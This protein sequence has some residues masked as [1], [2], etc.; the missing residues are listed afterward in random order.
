MVFR[1]LMLVSALAM[2][3]AVLTASAQVVT[4]PRQWIVDL[5]ADQARDSNLRFQTPDDSADV[6]TH[7]TG[8]ITGALQGKRGRFALAVGGGATEFRQLKSF[9][10]FTYDIALD[11]KRALTP[12]WTAY[13][14]GDA[15]SILS[16]LAVPLS[17]SQPLLPLS[18]S[19]SQT[20]A[21]GTSYRFSTRTTGNLEG[22]YTRITFDA[23]LLIGGWT[24]GGQ[25]SLYH[26]YAPGQSIGTVYGFEENSTFGVRVDVQTLFAQWQPTLGFLGVRLLAGAMRIGALDGLAA[27]VKPAGSAALFTGLGGGIATVQYK[28]SAEQAFGLGRMLL[29]DHVGLVYDRAAFLGNTIHL[30]A[31]RSWSRNPSD[32]S[33]AFTNTSGSLEVRRTLMGGFFVAADVSLRRRDDNLI[34]RANALRMLIGFTRHGE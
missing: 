28:R 29:T 32:E 9:N 8:R 1:R 23:P 25:A 30:A 15:R 2:A 13:L 6:I 5:Q 26:L 33:I 3:S 20:A 22:S 4:S 21:S 24:T 19:R 12:R 34:V 16:S 17:N 31:D 14:N 7:F 11:T 27:R 10:T 18:L